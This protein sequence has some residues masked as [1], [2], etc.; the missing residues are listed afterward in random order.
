MAA[1]QKSTGDITAANTFTS[2]IGLHNY[3]NVSVSGAWGGRITLQRAFDGTTATFYD[4]ASFVSNTEEYGFEPEDGV[5][6]QI[7]FKTG[8]YSSGTAVLRISQ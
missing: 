4:V 2:S 8:D 1:G 3:F 6:Y 5:L 7:G